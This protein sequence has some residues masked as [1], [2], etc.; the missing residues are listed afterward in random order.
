MQQLSSLALIRHDNLNKSRISYAIYKIVGP[1]TI[2][3]GYKYNVIRTQ[4]NGQ[5]V[6][7]IIDKNYLH[8]SPSHEIR[9]YV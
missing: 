4:I 3:T 7:E 2:Q 8:L 1:I 5:S 9:F 6:H